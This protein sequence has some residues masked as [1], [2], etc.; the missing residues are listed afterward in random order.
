MPKAVTQG[1]DIGQLLRDIED[2]KRCINCSYITAGRRGYWV[3]GRS[4][5]GQI[6]DEPKAGV[7]N[8]WRIERND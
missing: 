1:I 7:C 6:I 8:M 4:K 5:G 3:C 2:Y